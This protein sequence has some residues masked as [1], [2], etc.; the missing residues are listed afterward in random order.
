MSKREVADGGMHASPLFCSIFLIKN[1]KIARSWVAK[2]NGW[3]TVKPKA[4]RLLSPSAYGL[5]LR[6]VDW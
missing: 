2:Q 5:T 1:R 6:K 3:P 4:R